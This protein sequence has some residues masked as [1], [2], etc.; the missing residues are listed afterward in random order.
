M[1]ICSGYTGAVITVLNE[2]I[3]WRF[4]WKLYYIFRAYSSKKIIGPPGNDI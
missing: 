1:T 4:I 2:G 3:K